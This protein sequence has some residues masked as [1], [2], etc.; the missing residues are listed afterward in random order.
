MFPQRLWPAYPVDIPAGQSHW[1]WITVHTLGER[2]L[3]G[4][5]SGTVDITAGGD[6]TAHLP[7]EVEVLPVTLLTMHEAGLDLGSCTSGLPTLQEVSTLV[8]NNHTGMD[9]WFGGTQ[10]QMKVTNGKLSLDF[11]YL[12]DWMTRARKAGMTHVMWFLGG[13][14]YGFPD[15]L[16]LERDLYRA[17]ATSPAENAKLRAEYVQKAAANPDKI[18]PELRPLYADW[19]R[20]VGEH[21]MANN[22]PKLILHPF[23]EP[24]KWVQNQAW[25]DKFPGVIGTGPWI[26]DHF[27]DACALIHESSPHVLVGGDIHHAEPGLVFVKDIDVFCTNAIHEDLQ[28]G[29]KVRAAGTRFWQYSGCNDA[30]PAHRPRFAF[31]F[32]FGAFDS[33]GALVWAYNFCSRFDTSDR[34]EGQWGFGWYTPFGTIPTPFMAGLRE[35]LD[36]RRWIETYKA[37]V[38]AKNPQARKLLDDI[39]K[40]AIAFRDEGGRDTVADFYAQ[41]RQYQKMDEW[42]N[43]IIE[44]IVNPASQPATSPTPQASP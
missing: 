3:P 40:E 33:R 32:Y 25:K 2:T 22:W 37:T 34:G 4:R 16:N 17:R 29:D 20:Q 36:D 18:I 10:P 39:A 26:K 14:P 23:D 42:R 6:L 30:T 19:V 44:A 5:Y 41:I 12:D 9:I 43:R 31:G 38:V 11:T 24:A 8:E 21:A 27:K 28:L 1:F 15:T 13:D 7:I 35:G